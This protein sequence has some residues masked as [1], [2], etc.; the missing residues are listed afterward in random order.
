M[1]VTDTFWLTG[2]LLDSPAALRGHGVIPDVDRRT[3]ALD[4]GPDVSGDGIPDLWVV[5]GDGNDAGNYM[6]VLNGVDGT[7][8][9]R[10]SLSSLRAPK[11]VVVVGDRVYVTSSAAHDIY[12]YALDG[13]SET[14][15]LQGA[16]SPE[17]YVYQIQIGP[18]GKWYTANRF[19]G[20][21]GGQQ[22][23]ITAFDFDWTGGITYYT[24]AGTNFTGVVVY[25]A[26][27]L[28]PVPFDG[29]LVPTTLDMI[30]W[31][32]PE[33]NE[34]SGTIY[35]TVYF[36]DY[37]PEYGL[38]V[39]D[40]NTGYV[41]DPNFLIYAEPILVDQPL[42]TLDLSLATTLPLTY[43]KDYFWRVDVRDDSNPEQG[44]VVGPVW[45]FT[46]SN[47]PPLV[48]A[49][50]TVYTWL[51]DGSV[52]VQMTPIVTD[53]GRPN[54]PGAYTVLWEE[55]HDDPAVTID[56]PTSETTAVTI[57][58]VGSYV[59]KLTVDDSELSVS[60]TVTINVYNDACDA[61]KGVPGYTPL[62]A[63]F[64][65]DCDVDLDDF[66]VLSSDWL[67]STALD[68]PLP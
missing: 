44:V 67:Q 1:L 34:P 56:N 19:S 58:A 17:Y 60:D 37:Y 15:V 35:C 16:D 27:S 55:V 36:T 8:I 4:F 22:G 59:L 5:D 50:Q 51:V 13:S 46:A 68:A 2:V 32:N 18:D 42:N 30:R 52:V 38:E 20:D 57:T 61:A 45:K 48:D 65:N 54:P 47:T 33:P 39:I 6:L 25:P 28:L 62:A 64:D 53:D 10:W 43:G 40:P 7:T 24:A 49:G 31:T 66:V 41:K 26:G 3:V 11:D 9:Y 63:D 29:A 12:S 14:R 21:W 23:G